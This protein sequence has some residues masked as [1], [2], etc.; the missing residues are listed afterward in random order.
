MT[1]LFSYL[2][3][4]SPLSET[5]RQHLQQIVKRKELARKEHLLQAGQVCKSIWFIERGLLRCYT[6]RE[7]G[8]VC[9]WF[10]KEG[11]VCMSVESFFLQQSSLENIQ[12]ME[13]TELYSIEFEELQQIYREFPAFNITGRVLLEKYYL[14]SEQRLT[15]MRSR[16]APERYRWLGE[17][18]PELLQ[19]VP[20][21]YL[22]SYL[23]ITEVMLSNIKGRR[24][25]M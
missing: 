8:E 4:I 12:A 15:A 18:S 5:L 3:S 6:A 24:S 20:A 7:S 22:A 25:K 17:H 2:H 14:L 16:R 10:M 9:S 19:R 23:G 1:G 13:N 11:D 21:K